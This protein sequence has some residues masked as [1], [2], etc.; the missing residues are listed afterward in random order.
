MWP[1]RRRTQDRALFNI[2]DLVAPPTWAGVNVGPDQALRLAAV[3]S[4]VQLL[5]GS[6]STL[7]VHVY[8]EG[9]REPLPTPPLLRQPS[10]QLPLPDF[11]HATM[12]SLLLRG[13]C[14]GVVVDRSGTTMLPSQIELAH[15]DQVAVRSTDGG[16]EYRV[17][18]TVHD[19]ADIWHVRGFTMPGA[20]LGMSPIEYARQSIGLGLAAERFGAEFFGAGSIPQAILRNTAKVVRG[21]QAEEVKARFK[22]AVAGRDPFVTGVDWSYTPIAVAP[23]EAQFIQARS[24]QVAEIARFFNIP[25]QM[26]GAD[27]TTSHTY[28]STEQ[29]GSQFLIYS[30]RVWLTKLEVALARLLPRSQYVRFNP[31]A[32]LKASTLESYQALEVGIRS[33]LLT[34]NE[35]RAKQDLPPLEGG[36]RLAVAAPPPAQ[37]AA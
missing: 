31:G 15:P 35:A 26:I 11:L 18:G 14:Y 9:E 27:L 33:G 13:N 17:G 37:E 10:A 22:E 34:P 24:F 16:I 28:S 2:G 32:L 3:W 23:Q 1:F 19:P 25:A 7:P 12:V 5:A 36:D 30:L 20:V 4:C 21:D 6:V 8:R 29:L